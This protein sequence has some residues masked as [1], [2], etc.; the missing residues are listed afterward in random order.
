MGQQPDA[1]RAP[2]AAA[3]SW[4]GAQ[5]AVAQVWS[6]TQAARGRAR[7]EARVVWLWGGAAVAGAGAQGLA[8]RRPGSRTR[9]ASFPRARSQIFAAFC[10]Q[11]SESPASASA[12][13]CDRRISTV[14]DSGRRIACAVDSIFGWEDGFRASSE[15]AE[16]GRAARV[17]PYRWSRRPT[18]SMCGGRGTEFPVMDEDT[19][20]FPWRRR[21][22][23]D[24]DY[25]FVSS[26]RPAA[27]RALATHTASTARGL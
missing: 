24:P 17:S 19:W 11:C 1:D 21:R 14:L 20:P 13:W 4:P 25:V 2:R 5:G 10:V 8:Q 15:H 6:G 23:A 3:A 12:A 9:G 18:C 22:G 7:A 26:S 27:V 16:G